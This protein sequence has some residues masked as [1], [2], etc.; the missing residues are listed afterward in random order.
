VAMA[1]RRHKFKL[2]WKSQHVANLT[3]LS[4]EHT[5]V[6][7]SYTWVGRKGKHWQYLLDLVDLSKEQEVEGYSDDYWERWSIFDDK[8]ELVS[9][10]PPGID[11]ENEMMTWRLGV[12][13]WSEDP[14]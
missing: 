2:F 1:R 9:N 12:F 11:V 13:D 14:S 4:I 3:Y 10:S 5:S 6:T 8:G 7:C